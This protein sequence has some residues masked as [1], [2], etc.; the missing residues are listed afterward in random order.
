MGNGPIVG[1]PLT[2]GGDGGGRPT[3]GGDLHIPLL[4]HSR[5]VHSHQ[6]HYGCVYGGGETPGYKSVHEVVVAGWPGLGGDADGSLG[7]GTGGEVG[8][9]GHVGDGDGVLCGRIM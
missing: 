9:G 5:T 6:A 2:G 3:V 8:V 7:G 1:A 4:E